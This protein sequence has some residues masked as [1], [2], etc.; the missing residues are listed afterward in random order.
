MSQD[1]RRPLPDLMTPDEVGEMLRA[2]PKTIR[3]AIKAGRLPAQK[4]LG[5]WRVRRADVEE[6]IARTSTVPS[7]MPSTAATEGSE[8]S[9]AVNSGRDL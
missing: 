2:T 4:P 5:T 9:V 3:E 1:R 7:V 8:G 6:L